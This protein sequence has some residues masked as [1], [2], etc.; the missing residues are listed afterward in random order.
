MVRI[1]GCEALKALKK[2]TNI[3]TLKPKTV[4]LRKIHDPETRVLIDKGLC[5]WFPGEYK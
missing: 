2:M 4:F 5:L 3:S 1:S